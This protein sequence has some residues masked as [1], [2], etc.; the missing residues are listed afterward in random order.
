MILRNWFPVVVAKACHPFKALC[1]EEGIETFSAISSPSRLYSVD[2]CTFSAV[3]KDKEVAL[4]RPS[5]P[6]EAA[7]LVTLLWS[8][9]LL[10]TLNRGFPN[11]LMSPSCICGTKPPIVW[12]GLCKYQ[13]AH[14]QPLVETP[15]D[16]ITCCLWQIQLALH[17]NLHI[18]IRGTDS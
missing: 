7:I 10:H 5:M 16:P 15:P 9:F 4:C 3:W 2:L 12:K 6:L 1:V 13:A 17:F 14:S 8:S 11:V 18:M